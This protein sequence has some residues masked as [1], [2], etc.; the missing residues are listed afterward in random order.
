MNNL[1]LRIMEE[2]QK[3]LFEEAG[4]G[5]GSATTMDAVAYLPSQVGVSKS[6]M[7]K[8]KRKKSKWGIEILEEEENFVVNFED[9][10]KISV[11]KEHWEEFQ[12][13]FGTVL[14]EDIKSIQFQED[15]ELNPEDIIES[16]KE[17]L[18]SK[19][20]EITECSEIKLAEKVVCKILENF[21]C[22]EDL[23][24]GVNPAIS[25]FSLK[26]FTEQYLKNVL[27]EHENDLGHIEILIENFSLTEGNC[28]AG[29]R[30]SSEYQGIN[31]LFEVRV[32]FE[33]E[34]SF[35]IV[36]NDSEIADNLEESCLGLSRIGNVFYPLAG[37]I[38]SENGI[39]ESL[40]EVIKL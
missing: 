6:A 11:P 13:S 8:L 30:F 18:I 19:I 23:T 12:S 7:K 21:N 26:D 27:V 24:E 32:N 4:A 9:Q 17:E 20:K 31:L 34:C 35:S 36:V 37:Q 15:V 5:A 14:D 40:K 1:Y 38:L 29:S 3:D 28:L 2:N 16:R 25:L 22:K 33:K 10:L 39:I